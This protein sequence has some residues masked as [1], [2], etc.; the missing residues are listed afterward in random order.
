MGQEGVCEGSPKAFSSLPVLGQK[1]L[2]HGPGQTTVGRW[3]SRGLEKATRV[4]I[5][6]TQRTGPYTLRS[7]GK[8]TTLRTAP[9]PATSRSPRKVCFSRGGP[10]CSQRG[11]SRLVPEIPE[12]KHV[13]EA[14]GLATVIGFRTQP[15]PR[16]S[17][18]GPAPASIREWSQS[19]GAAT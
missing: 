10:N 8:E 15:S 14:E 13:S 12:G 4:A 11:A 7:L 17:L 16:C 19:R 2:G 1:S 9:R 18:G 6:G 3:G 5:L